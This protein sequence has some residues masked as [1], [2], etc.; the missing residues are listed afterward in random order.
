MPETGALRNTVSAP[1]GPLAHRE[2]RRRRHPAR[3]PVR[4]P[5]LLARRSGIESEPGPRRQLCLQEGLNR[6]KPE[7]QGQRLLRRGTRRVGADREAPGW[8]RR[9][10]SMYKAGLDLRIAPCGLKRRNG[11]CLESFCTLLR[12]LHARIDGNG[13]P[14]LHGPGIGRFQIR[15]P[16]VSHALA[17]GHEKIGTQRQLAG[18]RPS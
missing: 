2:K 12:E 9:G 5:S 1:S 14:S 17:V 15:E 10:K 8:V 11:D 4:L 18:Q 3:K 13:Q 6:S 16:D 7:T